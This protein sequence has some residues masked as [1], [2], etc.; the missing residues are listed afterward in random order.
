MCTFLAGAAVCCV[1]PDPH[2]SIATQLSGTWCQHIICCDPTKCIPLIKPSTRSGGTS[3]EHAAILVLSACAAGAPVA[4][5][6]ENA[7]SAPSRTIGPPA[8]LP[9]SCADSA[10][11]RWEWALPLR[12]HE[13]S[14]CRWGSDMQCCPTRPDGSAHWGRGRGSWPLPRLSDQHGLPQDA[15]IPLLCCAVTHGAQPSARCRLCECV[16]LP[17]EA[18]PPLWT[19]GA[20]QLPAPCFH[21]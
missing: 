16:R 9:A 2:G 8:P 12:R 1:L 17:Q 21:C 4:P 19:Q 5:T 14:A 15:W 10:M 11:Y 13:Q 6:A 20:E 3:S 18:S 7:T